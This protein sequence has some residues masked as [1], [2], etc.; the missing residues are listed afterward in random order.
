LLIYKPSPWGFSAVLIFIVLAV[1]AAQDSEW[2]S[3]LI[4]GLLS[5]SFLS[6]YMPK[7]II[8][9]PSAAVISS[10]TLILGLAWFL[11]D[12]LN[13]FGGLE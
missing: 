12:A 7:L 5:V 11:S 9:G 2:T 4:Y 13:L 6:K 1:L 3:T 8:F 10:F